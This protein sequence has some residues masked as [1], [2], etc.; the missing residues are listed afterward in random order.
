MP[1]AATTHTRLALNRF[2]HKPTYHPSDLVGGWW[3][4]VGCFAVW[5]GLG[6]VGTTLVVKTTTSTSN[7]STPTPKMRNTKIAIPGP[8]FLA[9]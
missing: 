6:S 2:V 1:Q 9:P 3:L 7:T 5:F 8:N 4:V